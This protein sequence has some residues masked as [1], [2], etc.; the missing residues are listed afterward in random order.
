[1]REQQ[2][3]GRKNWPL[4]AA[5]V[6]L[7]SL[8]AVGLLNNRNAQQ[9]AAQQ[10]A[11]QPAV[12]PSDSVEI[13]DR[14]II[15]AGLAELDE[16]NI[17]TDISMD[18]LRSA[19]LAGY[20]DHQL[21]LAERFAKGL[22]TIKDEEQAA[23]WF[24]LASENIMGLLV[25]KAD[26]GDVNS[27]RELDRRYRFGVGVRPDFPESNKWLM[28][29]ALKGDGPSQLNLGSRLERGDGAPRN[30]VDAYAWY[31][32]AAATG[33]LVAGHER[34]RLGSSSVD[35]TRLGQKRSREL[36]KQI[37]ETKASK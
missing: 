5:L 18:Q 17:E 3:A 7:M 4:Y 1:M 31:N 19:A 23:H 20:V 33:V 12:K 34:D 9:V 11:A 28:K 36:L 32:V 29:A 6:A 26:V 27:M 35:L 24:R 22:G 8:I 16:R 2:P 37:E 21:L 30:L 10:V 14:G 13:A 15:A 25:K